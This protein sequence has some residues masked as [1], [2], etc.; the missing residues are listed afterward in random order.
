MPHARL[1]VWP[2][3][4]RVGIPVAG[5]TRNISTPGTCPGSA[6]Y[7][8][9]LGPQEGSLRSLVT[10]SPE[11]PATDRVPAPAWSTARH[12]PGEQAP[13]EHT[14]RTHVTRSYRASTSGRMPP[15]PFPLKLQP[16]A[17]P[18]LPQV[19]K[20]RVRPRTGEETRARGHTAH[21]R[22]HRAAGTGRHARGWEP[23]PLVCL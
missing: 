5:P 4:P 21:A 16:P 17:G 7:G 3:T 20:P 19:G 14:C 9:A 6:G 11:P 2:V 13:G 15:T 12:P 22:P 10:L 18:Q 23:G 1:C 8:S